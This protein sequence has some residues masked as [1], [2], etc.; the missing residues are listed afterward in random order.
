[1]QTAQDIQDMNEKSKKYVV[2]IDGNGEKYEVL[3]ENENILTV[4]DK[5]QREYNIPRIYLMSYEIYKK[6]S[7]H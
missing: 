5:L 3:N 6:K 4:K 2:L 1:M 7:K